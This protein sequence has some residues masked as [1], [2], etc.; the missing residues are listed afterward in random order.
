[1]RIALIAP[2]V[3]PVPP[4]NYG[5]T[6]RVVDLLARGL[7]QLGQNVEVFAAAG[8][9]SDLPLA[10]GAPPPLPEHPA[11]AY[12]QAE[13]AHVRR[14]LARADEFDI[15]HD[16]TKKHGLQLANLSRIP[17]VSTMHNPVDPSRAVAYHRR[18]QHP[19]V[20]I[21]Q[22]QGRTLR[23]EGLNVVGVVPHGLDASLYRFNPH[24]KDYLLSLGRITADKGVHRAIALAKA[25][26][27]RLIIAGPIADGAET[28]FR[29]AI[30]PH[31]DGDQIQWLGA[32]G[33]ERKQQLFGE[34]AA[35][36]FPIQWEEPF[37]L[38]LIE[39]LA[40][41]TPVLATAH[42]AVPEIITDAKVG[43]VVSSDREL[44]PALFDV[45]NC[46]PEDCRRH[47][48]AH[49][50]AERMASDYLTIFE[51]Q[52]EAHRQPRAA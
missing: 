51:G 24:K 28:Y 9:R 43:R 5:G 44:L 30:E 2:I 32:V 12:A 31:L 47:V 18:P 48:E 10:E 41:G 23:A 35:F 17:M 46:R 36:V 16:H 13:T 11:H 15:F 19:W 25:A 49:F 14:A 4:G 40:C 21:S 7:Q 1:M 34:A 37:G 22:A 42:G 38:V 52:L 8:S 29:E 50:S 27:M 3:Y 6:E 26:R 45:L 33:G 39:A 20:A